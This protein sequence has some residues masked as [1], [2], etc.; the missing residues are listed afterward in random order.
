MVRY[1]TS[2]F[3]GVPKP[4]ARCP[5]C[6]A[7]SV[8]ERPTGGPQVIRHART[9]DASSGFVYQC[10][11]VGPRLVGRV[12]LQPSGR[13]HVVMAGKTVAMRL[14]SRPAAEKVALAWQPTDPADAE[15]YRQLV[16][17]L[18]ADHG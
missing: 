15:V 16:D 14:R 3:R 6:G 9:V 7:E 2:T 5:E 10:G 18:R 11:P 12:A 8:P 4:A 13:W 17:P 1:Y